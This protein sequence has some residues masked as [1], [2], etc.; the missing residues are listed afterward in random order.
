MIFSSN[1]RERAKGFGCEKNVARKGAFNSIWL[2]GMRIKEKIRKKTGEIGCKRLV[3]WTEHWTCN[4]IWLITTNECES[5]ELRQLNKWV[6]TCWHLNKC[7]DKCFV[8]SWHVFC[9][10][11]G[12]VRADLSTNTNIS[13]KKLIETN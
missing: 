1:L 9:V 5:F 6:E 8:K 2:I 11:G 3:L 7:F 4:N 12:P 13:D 10:F